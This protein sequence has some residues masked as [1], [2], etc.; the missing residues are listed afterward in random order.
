MITINAEFLPPRLTARDD[1][2]ITVIYAL[3]PE[4]DAVNTLF[5]LCQ[6]KDGSFFDKAPSDSNA[7]STSAISRYNVILA[8]M[9]GMGKAN[10]TIVANNCC[11]SFLNIKLTLVVGVSSVIPFRPDGKEII[12]S[13]VII[14]DSVIQYD[15]GRQL[16]GHLVGKDTLLDSLG[17]PNIKIYSKLV[18]A[19]RA[20]WL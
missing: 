12:L 8:Y 7:Y 3:P 18:K 20:L 14:S 19:K 4:A 17:R 5:N 2:K 6:D 10:A 9:P 13:D 1:F 11:T 15:L 16:L